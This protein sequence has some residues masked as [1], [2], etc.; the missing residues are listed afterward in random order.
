V[1]SVERV[2][3]CSIATASH[4]RQV[5]PCLRRLREYHPGVDTVLLVVDGDAAGLAGAARCLAVDAVV[6][7]AVL[8]GM[9]KR[10]TPAELCFA[11]KPFL[12]EHLLE[13]G[14]E[15]AHYLDGDCIVFHG[16]DP[17]VEDLA[18]ADVLLTPH[19]LSP[20]PDD[21]RT[22]GALTVLRGG[23][24]NGGYLGV[25]NTPEGRRFTRWLARMTEH[26]ARNAP[27]EGMCGDQRWLDLVP[28][29]FPGAAICRRAGANVAYWNLHERMLA[30]D[31]QGG[32]RVNG[33]PLLFFHYSGYRSD[34]PL[35]LSV[36]QN[37][38]A[39]ER[40]GQLWA[41]LE[42]YRGLLEAEGARQQGP[43]GIRR[44]LAGRNPAAR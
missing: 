38:H 19:S 11:L 29:L 31:A 9:R 5:S 13:A 40:G 18:A 32:F 22:P 39:V 42:E 10:Y 2:V 25:R 21:G 16:L 27:A 26:H 3:F 37:R 24:F 14:A 15:Q 17:L 6:P 20:I 33:E 41:L 12:L 7:P 36:H 23:V 30:G 4:L 8:S 44:W 1:K 34:R 43:R 35:Q 28:A